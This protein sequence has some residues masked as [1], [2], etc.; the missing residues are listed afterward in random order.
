MKTQCKL[1][2]GNT[3]KHIGT[4]EYNAKHC[5]CS[6]SKPKVIFKNEIEINFLNIEIR[7]CGGVW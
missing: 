6:L 2:F 1:K 4:V 7:F 5:Y 3:F